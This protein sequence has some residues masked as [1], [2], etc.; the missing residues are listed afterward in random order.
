MRGFDNTGLSQNCTVI[1]WQKAIHLSELVIMVGEPQV[2]AP[3]MYV[4]L[5]PQ[6][7]VGHGRALNVPPCI[8]HTLPTSVRQLKT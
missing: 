5:V 2:F 4:Q 7:I 8:A 1:V 3:H 6:H